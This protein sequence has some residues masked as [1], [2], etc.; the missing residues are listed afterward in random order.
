MVAAGE[1]TAGGKMGEVRALGLGEEGEEEGLGEGEGE[2]RVSATG[3]GC[4]TVSPPPSSLKGLLGR[5]ATLGDG[6]GVAS[7][8]TAS[9]NIER[10]SARGEAGE[11]PRERC[12]TVRTTAE[13]TDAESGEWKGPSGEAVPLTPSYIIGE[14]FRSADST[15]R[16]GAGGGGRREGGLGTDLDAM[17]AARMLVV[18]TGLSLLEDCGGDAVRGTGEGA[19]EGKGD[20]RDREG[21]GVLVDASTPPSMPS[22]SRSRF[23]SASACA[24]FS[25]L[26]SRRLISARTFESGERGGGADGRGKKCCAP[27][28]ALPVAD[29]PFDDNATRRR[30]SDTSLSSSCTSRVP[31]AR[32]NEKGSLSRLSCGSGAVPPPPRGAQSCSSSWLSAGL[33]FRPQETR[34]P[35]AAAGS[36][37]QK[38]WAQ[39]KISAQNGLKCNRRANTRRAAHHDRKSC[40]FV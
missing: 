36:I 28:P 8:A 10:G 34:R 3:R 7:F 31:D 19:E 20:A 1:D 39:L 30:R 32:P 13:A 21:D 4:T 12:D 40:T 16:R 35:S 27:P 5:K 23:I 9:P 22:R 25:L 6:G 2:E 37:P 18:L 11:G 26:A 14:A 38:Y 15:G 29:I 33:S 17:R 24:R